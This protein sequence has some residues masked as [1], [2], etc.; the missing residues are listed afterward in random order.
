[1]LKLSK[2]KGRKM[3]ETFVKMCRLYAIDIAFVCSCGISTLY[4]C[5]RFN[6]VPNMR[7]VHT[8]HLMASDWL[9]YF[10]VCYGVYLLSLPVRNS[11]LDKQGLAKM[12]MKCSYRGNTTMTGPM[13]NYMSD[14]CIDMS[15]ESNDTNMSHM[16]GWT[17]F[18]NF[19]SRWSLYT[20]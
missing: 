12:R 14:N 1:M 3:I 2:R 6:P 4:D 8:E 11:N 5:W 20:L 10:F 17:I 9:C 18:I 13:K 16:Y 15:S 7:Y 19:Q